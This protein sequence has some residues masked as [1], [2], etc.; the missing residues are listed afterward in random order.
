M[1]MYKELV[2]QW[3]ENPR[4]RMG[5]VLIVLIVVS[6]GLLMVD[7][8]RNSLY[9]EYSREYNTLLK[10]RY[11]QQQSDW[12]ER[13][14]S[15]KNIRL[16]LENSLWRAE[17]K[18]LAQANVQTWFN[19]KIQQFN[20]NGLE[21]AGASVQSDPKTPVIWQVVVEIKGTLHDRGL[22]EL[23]NNIEQNPQ[24]MQVEQLQVN[25]DLQDL[26][27]ITLQVN[28]YFQVPDVQ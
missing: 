21:I 22:L 2:S 20:L 8:Y 16:Q 15:I 19:E 10:L 24:L 23:L 27:R 17:T 4:L 28:C 11:V 13:A 3:Q 7:D 12:K 18:G 5:L 1:Q 9:E 6:N 26:L 25:R 14:E